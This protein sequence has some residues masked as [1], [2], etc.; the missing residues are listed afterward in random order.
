MRAR[1]D[2]E[3]LRRQ[4]MAELQRAADRVCSLILYSDYPEVDVLI[5]RR[6]LRDLCERMYPDRLGLFDMVYE[7]RFDRLWE[8]FRC[9]EEMDGVGA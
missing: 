6:K 1:S 5:E 7:S 4:R 2:D 8:Q 9:P 3:R